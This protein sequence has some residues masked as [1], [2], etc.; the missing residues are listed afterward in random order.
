MI[1]QI[2]MCVW[3]LS[4]PISNVGV[5]KVC[6]F[7]HPW[8]PCHLQWWLFQITHHNE[9]A[10]FSVKSGNPAATYPLMRLAYTRKLYVWFRFKGCPV[11][12][13]MANQCN[14]IKRALVAQVRYRYIGGGKIIVSD[15]NICQCL[16]V[17]RTE[18][19]RV[20]RLKSAAIDWRRGREPHARSSS[21]IDTALTIYWNTYT[22]PTMERRLSVNH[23]KLY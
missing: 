20:C 13:H 5:Y 18:F 23:S 14:L 10:S 19:N 9:R 6:V 21:W 22:P 16:E 17:F 7:S 1:T 11:Q 8:Y 12:S 15:Y 2:R 4:L 3:V